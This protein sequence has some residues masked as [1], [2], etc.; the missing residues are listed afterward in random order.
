[1]PATREELEMRLEELGIATKSWEHDPVFTVEEAKAL[2]G[3]IPGGH[4]KNLFLKD[5]KGQLWLV[6]TLEE[7][8]VDLKSLPAKIGAARLSFGKPDLLL[9]ALGIEPG[10]VTPFAVINDDTQRVNVIL[11]EKMMAEE[12]VNFH[13]LKNNATTTI[14]SQDLLSFIKACGHSPKIIAVSS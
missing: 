5:K 1:M 4:C 13:P 3:E 9:E 14:K 6:V 12:V 11:D 8:Q 2:R 7:A 10:S